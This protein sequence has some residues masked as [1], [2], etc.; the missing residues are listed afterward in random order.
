[1]KI[2]RRRRSMRAVLRPL[3][4]SFALAA[5]VGASAADRDFAKSLRRKVFV[6]GAGPQLYGI[7]ER[8]R[9]YAVPGVSVAVVDNCRIVEIR[10]FGTAS[11]QGRQV[12]GETLFQAGSLSKV[13]AAVGALKLVEQGRLDLDTDISTRVDGWTPTAK[14]GEAAPHP[15][16]LRHLLSHGAG[17]SVAGFKGYPVGSPVPTLRQVL[18]GEPPANTAPVRTE[19]APGV[20]WRYSGGGFVVTQLLMQQATDQ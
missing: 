7:E 18:D 17:L 20:E 12:T 14:T 11:P 5:S 19:R 3:L 8:M 10:G 9:H 6:E 4:L 1:M 13:A 16:T 2:A 15:L